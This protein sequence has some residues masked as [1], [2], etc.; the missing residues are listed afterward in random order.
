MWLPRSAVATFCYDFLKG[1]LRNPAL[2]DEEAAAL[3]RDPT[4]PPPSDPNGVIQALW[5]PLKAEALSDGAPAAEQFKTPSSVRGP[6]VSSGSH[7]LLLKKNL[8]NPHVLFF[9]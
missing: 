5:A 3:I 4:Q 1:C 9:K 6:E 7:L 2:T 8:K